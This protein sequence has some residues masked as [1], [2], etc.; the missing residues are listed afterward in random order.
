ML[1]HVVDLQV[2]DIFQHRIAVTTTCNGC[3]ATSSIT[4]GDFF[5]SLSPTDKDSTIDAAIASAQVPRDFER[6]CPTCAYESSAQLTTFQ[7]S[8]VLLL[9]IKRFIFDPLTLTS[10]KLY[11]VIRVTHELTFAGVPF[12]L[13]AVVLHL[14]DIH[15]GHY[16]CD[17]L[18]STGERI[19]INDSIVGAI[20]TSCP[21]NVTPYVLMYVRL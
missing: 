17:V 1:N 16:V 11:G 2:R 13:R 7:P 12:R 18:D 8:H 21:S 15:G 20:P 3:G 6:V 9:Q 14:G 10:K 4:S 5:I 19:S